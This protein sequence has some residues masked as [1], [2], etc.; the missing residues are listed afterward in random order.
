MEDSNSNHKCYLSKASFDFWN[1]SYCTE[2]EN[3]RFNLKVGDDID[4]YY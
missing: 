4:T 3:W 1:E 2:Y